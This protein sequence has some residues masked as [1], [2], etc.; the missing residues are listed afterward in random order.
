M[1]NKNSVGSKSSRSSG[2]DQTYWDK[3][4]QNNKN[5]IL[6]DY[7]KTQ[8]EI[9]EN[10]H[11]Q[12]NKCKNVKTRE[13]FNK[14]KCGK[15]FEDYRVGMQQRRRY[16]TFEDNTEAGKEE[17]EREEREQEREERE[18]EKREKR[19]KEREEKATKILGRFYTPRP[20]SPSQEG[21]KRKS[22]KAVKK[23]KK[24][25]LKK[26]TLKKRTLKK[27]TLKKRR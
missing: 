21:G 2:G 16:W 27:R 26:R 12:E 3:K 11:T 10:Y 9:R 14:N 5:Q 23:N 8:D 7:K 18:R 13:E 17:K 24:R 6:D 20:R 19:E 25:T 1:S 15:L 4:V 22:R